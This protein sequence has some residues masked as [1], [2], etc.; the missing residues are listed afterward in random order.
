MAELRSRVRSLA[1]ITIGA[2]LFLLSVAATYQA[3]GGAEM[4]TKFFSG[5]TPA[6]MAA[7][8]GSKTT[9]LFSPKHYLA[10]GFNHPLFLVLTLAVALSIGGRSIAGDVESGRAELLYS[11]PVARSRILL[12]HGLMWLI[13]QTLVISAAVAGAVAGTRL[14]PDLK[15][16]GV[17]FNLV[18]VGVQYFGVTAVFAGAAFAAS[19]LVRSRSA[20]LGVAI[21]VTALS[22]LVNFVSLLWEPIESLGRATPFGY[23]EPMEVATGGLAIGKLAVLLGVTVILFVIADVALEHRDLV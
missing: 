8:S 10:F 3:F 5:K 6:A 20:A 23:Y 4:S 14:S 12:A 16:S 7:F 13:A 1:A 17:G 15:N 11:R 19:A 21:G 18:W 9:D 22:Y 2:F